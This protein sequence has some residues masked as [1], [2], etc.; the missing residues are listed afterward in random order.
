MVLK[1]LVPGVKDA[2]ETDLGAQ[3]TWIFSDFL[4]RFRAAPEQDA[5]DNLF[6]LQGQ[7]RQFVR[8]CENDMGVARGQQFGAPCVKPAVAGIA[9]AAGAMPVPAR[10]ER[11]GLMA[12][13]RTLIDMA[14]QRGGAAAKDGR[15]HLEVQPGEPGGMPVDESLGCGA[16]DIGQLKEWPVHLT[17]LRLMLC[18][19]WRRCRPECVERARD[20]P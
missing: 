13:A 17:V 19:V 18:A 5:V 14:T 15:E 8:Q 16:Y 2:E 1:L 9:L 20:C 4:K 11:D 3:M 12:A 10:I 6:V 7:W